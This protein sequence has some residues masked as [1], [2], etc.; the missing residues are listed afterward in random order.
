MV[1]VDIGLVRTRIPPTFMG[2]YQPGT[3]ASTQSGVARPSILD[4]LFSM[5]YSTAEANINWTLKKL[6]VSEVAEVVCCSR[7]IRSKHSLAVPK[8]GLDPEKVAELRRNSAQAEVAY[9]EMLKE[10]GFLDK[11]A[12]ELL[13]SDRYSLASTYGKIVLPGDSGKGAVHAALEQ[14]KFAFGFYVEGF[15]KPEILTHAELQEAIF[16][17][18]SVLCGRCPRPVGVQESYF[19]EVALKKRMGEYLSEVQRREEQ[20]GLRDPR[21]L[22]EKVVLHNNRVLDERRKLRQRK[23][24]TLRSVLS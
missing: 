17:I 19:S 23:D 12:K 16:D 9:H 5:D 4:Y 2:K 1:Y 22:S 11:E 24:Q 3:F 18:N 21:R 7:S 13:L 15:P 6:T 10:F 14:S 20:L 8:D